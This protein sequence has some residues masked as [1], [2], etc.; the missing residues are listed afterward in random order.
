MSGNVGAQRSAVCI[1]YQG[2]SLSVGSGIVNVR[3][4]QK[5]TGSDLT[6]F[7]FYRDREI[8]C[9]LIQ[10][11]IS[12]ILKFKSRISEHL[13]VFNV[14]I[15]LCDIFQHLIDVGNIIGLEA[16]CHLIRDIL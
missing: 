6:G 5:L 13:T 11:I 9:K 7:I 2:E 16:I 8:T 1:A 4:F 12:L 3:N 15:E 10:K 14:F